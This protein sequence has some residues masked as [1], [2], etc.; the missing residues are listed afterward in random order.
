ML[1]E[2]ETLGAEI[3]FMQFHQ[4]C[5]LSREAVLGDRFNYIEM[6][7]LLPGISDLS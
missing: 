6:W 3:N 5:G 1:K 4:Q 2:E 7:D